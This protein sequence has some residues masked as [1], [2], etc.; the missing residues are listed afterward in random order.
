MRRVAQFKEKNSSIL[1]NLNSS[2]EREA[3]IHS[4]VVNVLVDRDQHGRRVL[5]A[6]VGGMLPQHSVSFRLDIFVSQWHFWEG[7][8][9]VFIPSFVRFIF[10]STFRQL[11]WAFQPVHGLDTTSEVRTVGPVGI[12]T[13]EVALH[14]LH[15]GKLWYFHNTKVKKKKK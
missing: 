7:K 9:G 13:L 1:S 3:L 11:T 14:S 15:A 6:N 10:L 12:R 5:V 2:S 8:I 4:R